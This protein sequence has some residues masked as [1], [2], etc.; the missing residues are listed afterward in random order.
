MLPTSYKDAILDRGEPSK[1][2]QPHQRSCAPSVPQLTVIIRPYLPDE[3]WVRLCER[4]PLGHD[5][6]VH[7]RSFS[8]NSPLP[9]FCA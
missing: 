6:K 7:S 5:G 8:N 3:D 1:G 9:A 4:L 2:K